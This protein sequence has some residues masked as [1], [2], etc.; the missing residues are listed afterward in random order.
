[1]L[2]DNIQEYQWLG[3]FTLRISCIVYLL[4]LIPQIILN[5]QRKSVQGLSFTMH[6]I[7]LIAY[8]CDLG[9][10]IGKQMQL[11]YI[12]V[13][14]IGCICLIIQHCQFYI[15]SEILPKYYKLI[16]TITCI[17]GLIVIST[18]IWKAS[19]I[20]YTVLGFI[21]MIGWLTYTIPQIIKN[22]NLN[23]TQALSIM[24]ILFG[25]TASC[26]D[27]IS[28]YILDWGLPNK[29]G[30]PV[31]LCLKLILLI[32]ILLYKFRHNNIKITE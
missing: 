3:Y 10:G 6:S 5:I 25:L 29:I 14:I 23:N 31:S 21:S 19:I 7:L 8:I 17:L 12:A 32:Q 22:T 13:S 9:Y 26:C 18:V 16:T 2:V 4:F 1:M 27:S 11:E 20:V 24:F 28:A 30:S 15:L